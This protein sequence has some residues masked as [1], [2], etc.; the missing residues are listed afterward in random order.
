MRTSTTG[1]KRSP[2]GSRCPRCRRRSGL[3]SGAFAGVAHPRRGDLAR[4]CN[5]RPRRRAA[6][7]GRPASADG[8]AP[9]AGG[10]E[11]SATWIPVRDRQRDAKRWNEQALNLR[12]RLRNAAQRSGLAAFWQWWKGEL[13]A[14]M[15]VRARTALRRRRLRP[16]VAFESDTA[17]VWA[18]RVAD[19]TLA[20]AEIARIPL[21]GDAADLAR[22]GHAAIDA[23]PR[24]AYGGVVTVAKVAVA[25]PPGAGTAQDDHASGG[26]RGESSPDARLRPR[27]SYAVQ[28]GRSV[29]RRARRRARCREKGDPRPSGGGAQ[30]AQSTRRVVASKTGAPRSSPSRRS[31][32][33]IRQRSPGRR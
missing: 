5:L 18:P 4:W 17:V 28:A 31:R 26:G 13:A 12:Q 32:R 15:P 7:A 20:F 11:R 27:S 22:D 9:L 24:V 23:L 10:R 1:A 14:L 2:T 16:I 25:L 29:F 3:G 33:R 19:G 30:V 21:S 6:S 8:R